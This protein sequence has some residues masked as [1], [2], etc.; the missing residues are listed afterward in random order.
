MT[1][2]IAQ[3][4]LDFTGLY[5]AELLTELVLRYWKHPHADD[6]EFRNTLLETAAEAL[7][8]SVAGEPL[9]EGLP[10]DQMNIV[11]AIWFAEFNR[12]E[13]DPELSHDE[14][15]AVNDWLSTLRRSI[16]SC[17]CDQNFLS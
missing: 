2:P 4:S 9:I 13:H 6:A 8:A 11:S 10:P 17:F 1:K 14:R 15:A 16:P 7:R 12:V 5:E 3:V